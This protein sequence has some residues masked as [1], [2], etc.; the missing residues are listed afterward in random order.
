MRKVKVKKVNLSDQGHSVTV[1]PKPRDMLCPSFFQR[2]YL[3]D[4][5]E[6]QGQPNQAFYHIDEGTEVQRKEMASQGSWR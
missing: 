1:R 3:R 6:F 4:R 2:Q 5:S